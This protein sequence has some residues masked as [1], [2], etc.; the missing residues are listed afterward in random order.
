[1]EWKIIGLSAVINAVLTIL[2]SIVF[3]PL[4]FIGPLIG[5]FLAAY[6]SK[7]YEDYDVMDEKDGAIVGAVC[8][9][10][11]G[12]IIA[13]FLILEIGTVSM[14]LKPLIGDNTLIIGYII[15]QLS[16][17]ISFVLGLV[18]GVIGVYVKN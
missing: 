18:G 17:L 12:F 1:M 2:L 8:G 6:L 5:G 16:V 10:M 11:G 9:L 15:L 4:F 7:G 3:F 14:F 13:L